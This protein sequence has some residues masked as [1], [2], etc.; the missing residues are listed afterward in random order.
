MKEEKI[1]DLNPNYKT[2]MGCLRYVLKCLG[3]GDHSG[4]RHAIKDALRRLGFTQGA[5]DNPKIRL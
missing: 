4:V 5:I 2:V 1:E 3:R